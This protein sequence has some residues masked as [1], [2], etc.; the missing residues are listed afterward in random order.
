MY[1]QMSKKEIEDYLDVMFDMTSVAGWARLVKELE[2]EVDALKEA[3]VSPIGID[4][5]QF[6]R[7]QINT[8]QRFINFRGTLENASVQ[9]SVPEVQD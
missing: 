3:L 9:L 4:Q 1:E 7:G 2:D 6:L 5:V 8:L